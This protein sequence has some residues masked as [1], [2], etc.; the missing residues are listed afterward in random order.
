MKIQLYLQLITIIMYAGDIPSQLIDVS[1]FK[2]LEELLTYY[3]S[4]AAYVPFKATHN[5]QLALAVPTQS[6]THMH[7]PK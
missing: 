3:V 4:I 5:H 6:F 1:T 2:L 7:W